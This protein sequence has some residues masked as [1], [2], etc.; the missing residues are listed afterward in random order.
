VGKEA[1][2]TEVQ[3]WRGGLPRKHFHVP[4]PEPPRIRHESKSA[5]QPKD[6]VGRDLEEWLAG[7]TVARTVDAD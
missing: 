1:Q 6:R 7:L 4:L 5:P 2:V 3:D